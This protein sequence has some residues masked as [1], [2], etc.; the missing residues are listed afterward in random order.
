[1][2]IFTTTS[3]AGGALPSGV[4]EVGGLVLDMI[5]IN[6]VRV[7]SQLSASSLYVGFFDS[8]VPTENRG[9][10]GTIGTQ[11][12]LAAVLAALG[13]G[14]Q[15]LAV[16]ISVY[17]GDTAPG[18]FDENDNALLINGIE[19]GNF[20]DVAT[21]ETSADGL[22]ILSETT[23]FG[24]NILSTGF[25]YETD[26]TI[27][28]DV[29]D[30]LV[31]TGSSVFQLRDDATAFDNY[32]DFTQGID[33]DLVDVGTPP[34]ISPLANDDFVT[35]LQDQAVQVDIGANDSDPDGSIV[36]QSYTQASN[37]VVSGSGSNLTYTPNA[38]FFGTDSFVYTV[39]DDD[40]ATDTATV[41]ITVNQNGSGP[42]LPNC[43][44]VSRAGTVV[45]TDGGNQTLSG[46]M[47]A[48]SFYVDVSESSGRDR[49]VDF[50]S[51]DIFV[52]DA[53][54]RD[55]DGDGVVGFGANGVLNLD[56]S[57]SGDTVRIDGVTALRYLGESCTDVFVYADAATRL[58]GWSEGLVS[59]DALSGDAGDMMAQTFFWDSALDIAL[60]E[61]KLL[62]F[63]ANDRIAFTAALS[64][65][66]G[67]GIVSFGAN[68]IL[69]LVSSD[70]DAIGSITISDTGGQQVTSLQFDG[71]SEIGGVT[72]WFYSL[73]D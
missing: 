53:L 41:F 1:M 39:T 63:G 45:A 56:A 43:P 50:E 24:D 65:R 2:T 69:D 13:G 35:T 25:F 7:V 27:L 71:S 49:I 21:Q 29:F 3:P 67:D 16:R 8:G 64:D 70:G 15:S 31:A 54:L 52:T 9:N 12:G 37:G 30:S 42:V 14:L 40:G 60:G 26:P 19:I 58:Q 33:G 72:Y 17:D 6:G 68:N 62:N 66:D 22:T 38:G 20:S 57:Q 61:D 11:T 18:D 47:G 46:M 36:G 51:R 5:G 10:P 73:A 23:G 48:N 4:T 44:T 32:F 59:N 28:Q 34:N 55:R